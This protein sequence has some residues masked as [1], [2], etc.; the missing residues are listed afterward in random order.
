M[1]VPI[2]GKRAAN[3]DIFQ[4]YPNSV[5][6]CDSHYRVCGSAECFVGTENGDVEMYDG[7]FD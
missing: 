2:F 5:R 1:R 7:N 6:Y 3:Q 4:E